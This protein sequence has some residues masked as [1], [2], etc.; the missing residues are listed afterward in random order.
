MKAVIKE[1]EDRIRM[2]EAIERDHRKDSQVIRRELA[3]YTCGLKEA[4]FVIEKATKKK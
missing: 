1:L 2:A 3:G 4:L